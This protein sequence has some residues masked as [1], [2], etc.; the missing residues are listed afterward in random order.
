M[1]HKTETTVVKTE[2]KKKSKVFLVVLVLLVALGGWFGFSKY[3]HARHHAETDDAQVEAN[4]SPIVPRVSGYVIAVKVKDNQAVKKGDTLVILDDRDLRLKLAAA[5][6]ALATAQSNLGVA[7]ATTTAATSNVVTTRASIET[8][9]AQIKTAE[10]SVWRANQ[11]FQRY[12]NLYKDHSITKQQY[13]QA[14]A[15]KQTAERQLQV[16]REQKNQAAQQTRSV[17]SQGAAT[18][19]QVNVASAIIQQRK[20]EVEDAKLNLS[21]SVITAPED[22]IVSKVNVQDGQLVQTGQPLFNVVLSD[23]T[24]V[25]AN[26]KETQIGKMKQGQKVTVHVDAFPDH[27]FDATL[28]SFSPATGAKFALLP[29]DNASGNFV[30]VVQRVPVKIEFSKNDPFARQLR[31]GMNVSVDVHLN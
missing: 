26:F 22:G 28:S 19:K 5:E 8:I 16:L 1:A 11:D 29:P 21:Y 4:I 7:Q 15:A 23:E 2:K 20:V 6:A 10:V 9:E 25:V 30:K 18:G 24:W 27:D 17:A 14:L 12:E 13:E 31:A 3:N